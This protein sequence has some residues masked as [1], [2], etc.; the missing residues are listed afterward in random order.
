MRESAGRLD[1][2]RW[3]L[4]AGGRAR[5]SAAKRAGAVREVR[6]TDARFGAEFIKRDVILSIRLER[7]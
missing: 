5:G 3:T 4:D 1:A 7:V 6:A 2:R